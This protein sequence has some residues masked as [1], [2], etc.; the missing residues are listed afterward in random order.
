MLFELMR[1][2]GGSPRYCPE[3]ARVRAWFFT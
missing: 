1:K 3:F 2:N